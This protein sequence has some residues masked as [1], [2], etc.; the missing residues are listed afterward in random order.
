MPFLHPTA[1][2]EGGYHEVLYQGT[3][4]H[5]FA[6]FITGV[7]MN[8]EDLGSGR[9]EARGQAPRKLSAACYSYRLIAND[10]NL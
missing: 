4:R 2:P 1:S 10:S 7:G 3:T 9:R 8:Q 6:T 5:S